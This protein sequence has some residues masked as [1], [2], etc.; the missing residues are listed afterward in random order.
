MAD[1]TRR[2]LWI[3]ASAGIAGDMLLGALIDAGAP[4][5]DVQ[6]AVDAVA[7]AT[8]RLTVR[9][10][11]RASL[12]ATKVDVQPV[13]DDQPSRTWAD[14]HAMITGADLPE[15]TRECALTVF[16]RLAVAEGHVHGV[17]ADAVHFHEVGA[18][19]SIADV[20]GCAAA[21]TALGVDRISAGPIALG[22]G[23]VPTAHGE[24]PV[25][26]PAVLELCSGWR[27]HAGGEGELAT[28]T[29][30]ALVTALA[31][32]C[33]DLPPMSVAAAGAGAG[34]RDR[35]GRANVVRVVVGTSEATGARGST[36][37]ADTSAVLIEANV[38]DL[39]PRVWPS[40]LAGL[41]QAGAS[42]AWLVPILMKK[43]R[44]A[45]T[46]SVLAPTEDAGGLRRAIFDLVPT[47]GVRE[48]MVRKT[49][50]TREW[51]PVDVEGERVR[52][53]VALEGDRIVSATPEFE[54]VRAAA[55]RLGR[56]VRH[57]LDAAT[58]LARAAGLAPGHDVP[59]RPA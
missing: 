42:D 36:P 45:H 48:S 46:L 6:A 13:A 58:A 29:G 39:D 43:G 24:L 54:D 31:T 44:P 30:V 51:H 21:L 56:P 14:I 1:V 10:V 28:P 37:D 16:E 34:T 11:R 38:D 3:D 52:I 26:V 53:K 20:V 40:V 33:E 47:F 41:L 19:D 12:R 59:E 4:L 17:P 7:P 49:A 55:G 50:L 27:V 32:S 9:E 18:W 8:V 22:S 35:S 25:P 15:R 23:T 2:V 5:A 57:V